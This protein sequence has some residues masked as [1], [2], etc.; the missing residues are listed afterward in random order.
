[1][2]TAIH[3]GFFLFCFLFLAGQV[4]AS[5]Y[6]QPVSADGVAAIGQ[7]AVFHC[8]AGAGFRVSK[9]EVT[10][11]TLRELVTNVGNH[12]TALHDLGVEFS[13]S[14]DKKNSCL[15]F[16]ATATT[17]GTAVVCEVENTTDFLM[18]Y[19]SSKVLTLFYGKLV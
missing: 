7:Q 17:N 8:R 16:N 2:V 3:H 14:G 15:T 19:K 18:A 4:Q 11:P 9:W 1:M 6:I 10:V 5:F 12:V 13:I